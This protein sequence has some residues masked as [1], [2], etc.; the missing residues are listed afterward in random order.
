MTS[1]QFW[2]ATKDEVQARVDVWHDVQ[3]RRDQAV[4]DLCAMFYNTNR[5]KGKAAKKPTDF[6]A[7]PR[8]PKTVE[9]LLAIARAIFK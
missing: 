4:A 5:G 2:S 9:Q 7:K 1:E 6:I 3:A 8:K